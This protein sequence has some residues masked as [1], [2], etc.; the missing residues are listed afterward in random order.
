MCATG[1][2]CVPLQVGLEKIGD[3]EAQAMDGVDRGSVSRG[4]RNK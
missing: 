1:S 3:A 2:G 4:F